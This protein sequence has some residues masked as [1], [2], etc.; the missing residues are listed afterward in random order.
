MLLTEIARYC[1]AECQKADWK[2]HKKI[3]GVD[4]AKIDETPLQDHVRSES[5]Q[6]DFSTSSA[7]STESFDSTMPAIL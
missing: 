3:C 2:L 6:T 5:E 4:P 7:E 1:D